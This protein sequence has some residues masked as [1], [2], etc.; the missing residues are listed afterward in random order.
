MY[1]TIHPNVSYQFYRTVFNSDFNI[2][3][4]YPRSDTCSTC[5]E[6]IANIK[7]VDENLTTEKDKSKIETLL[8]EKHKLTLDNS[9]H[10]RKASVFYDRK[11]NAKK[12]AA[13]DPLFTA[14]AMDYQ[15]NLNAPNKST[16]DVYY[17]RQLTC[18]SFNIHELASNDVY[19]Y[20]YDETTAK[21]GANDVAS[22]LYDYTMNR[23]SRSVNHLEI[24]CDGCCGQN[25]NY[26][27]IRF[28]FWLVHGIARFETVKITF[29]VRGHSYLE[30]DKDMA[31][32]NQKSNID[33]P[34]EWWEIFRSARTSPLPYNVV[35]CEQ[36]M[37]W[38][39]S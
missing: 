37:F 4:G 21:K 14:I 6:F 38:T 27:V 2:A 5:D 23:L 20:C 33:L 22:L 36:R 15:K 24:F 11:R 19:F 29:P 9:L 13:S 17:R 39:F 18:I 7:H 8:E 3:F 30:C 25:K 28:L 34:G 32:I 10:K 26:T 31:A 35:E 1:N 12:R 16:T